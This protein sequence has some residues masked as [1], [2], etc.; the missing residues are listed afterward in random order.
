M[1]I[2]NGFMK[3]FMPL[4]VA[5]IYEYI[6]SNVTNILYGI[7]YFNIKLIIKELCNTDITIN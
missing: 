6:C 4:Y 7:Y 1:D 5:H 3:L 2:I